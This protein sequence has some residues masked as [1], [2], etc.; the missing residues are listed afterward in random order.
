MKFGKLLNRVRVDG[1]VYLNYKEL[2]QCLNDSTLFIEKLKREINYVDTFFLQEERTMLSEQIDES[3]I[4]QRL[5]N[6]Q[7]MRQFIVLN[8]LAVFKIAKKHDKHVPQ[9][10]CREEMLKRLATTSFY[11]ALTTSPVFTDL[12]QKLREKLGKT[13]GKECVVCLTRMTEACAL[14]CGHEFCWGC[15]A[16]MEERQI[17]ECPICRSPVVVHPT[18]LLATD[19]LG[20]PVNPTFKIVAREK[21]AKDGNG[22]CNVLEESDDDREG[23]KTTAAIVRP[24]SQRYYCRDCCMI[25]NSF[26][27]AQI[28][29]KGQRHQDQVHRLKEKHAKE[30]LPYQESA[31]QVYTGDIPDDHPMPKPRRSRGNRA[32]A[33]QARR[34]SKPDVEV[35]T[36]N[37]APSAPHPPQ[38]S[39][40]W[41]PPQG[42]I[43]VPIPQMQWSGSMNE[44]GFTPMYPTDLSIPSWQPVPPEEPP[45]RLHHMSSSSSLDLLEGEIPM[46]QRAMPQHHNPY[47]DPTSQLD[48]CP[49]PDVPPDQ[50][51]EELPVQGSS[52]EAGRSGARTP[53]FDDGNVVSNSPPM[54]PINMRERSN[55]TPSE[56]LSSRASTRPPSMPLMET[57][58]WVHS[59]Q[60]TD[61]V[62][63][64]NLRKCL[65]SLLQH[66]EGKALEELQSTLQQQ[67]GAE[68]LVSEIMHGV[69]NGESCSD[70]AQL[71]KVIVNLTDAQTSLLGHDFIHL[72]IMSCKKAVSSPRKEICTDDMPSEQAE[73][74]EEQAC[75]EQY[76]RAV[77]SIFVAELFSLQL[78][79]EALVHISLQTM[80]FG[81][82]L[83]SE[84]AEVPVVDPDIECLS[85]AC[86]VMRIVGS[87]L[88]K[89][90]P[91][92][93]ERYVEV[94]QRLSKNSYG[95]VS[96]LL[97]QV[98]RAHKEGW[99]E[100]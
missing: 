55:S 44:M 3:N 12:E 94:L 57:S 23:L 66:K 49:G 95:R 39:T 26:R 31:L 14:K 28:H 65:S 25:L 93:M 32:K 70:Y 83:P 13:D 46:E 82:V 99:K 98:L 90:S 22:N 52:A 54:W 73:M 86:R 2:K 40:A 24:R 4:D 51:P 42:G 7:A 16:K 1:R 67:D 74:L 11:H 75:K 10:P 47:Y 6:I 56:H 78:V 88:H 18:T 30:D 15:L 61:L 77:T 21:R 80:L 96:R 43:Y 59:F 27:Q 64:S 53:S 36:M 63:H 5:K 34:L 92:L 35:D 97:T 84:S 33:E 76:R 81:T 91:A 69:Y 45:T 100:R 20:N 62:V 72:L 58:Q 60:Q 41:T 89:N 8:I 68:A 38:P 19:I 50:L 9:N 79:P 48:S 37:S 85:V 71:C 87:K 29:M 17:E